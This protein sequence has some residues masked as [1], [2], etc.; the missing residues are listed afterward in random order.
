MGLQHSCVSIATV[1]LGK[2][3]QRHHFPTI[4]DCIVHKKLIG[5]AISFAPATTKGE[6]KVSKEKGG[7]GDITVASISAR[8][9]NVF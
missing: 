9:C 4:T 8:N 6:Q 7:V 2:A 1:I 5:K 3:R